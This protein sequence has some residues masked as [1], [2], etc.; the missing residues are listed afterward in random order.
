MV[1]TKEQFAKGLLI[2]YSCGG[3][4]PD[5]ATLNVWYQLIKDITGY[6]YQESIINLVKTEK[7]L[8]YINFPYEIYDRAKRIESEQINLAE[9][10]LEYFSMRK[11]IWREAELAIKEDNDYEAYVL[12]FK[13]NQ[14]LQKYNESAFL[15]HEMRDNIL[16]MRKLYLNEK[17]QGE[18]VDGG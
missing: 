14:F 2:F 13:A 9:G 16:R 6:F 18:A 7:N 4:N 15:D 8:G 1:M 3:P 12:C 10:M 17:K 5:E 11:E